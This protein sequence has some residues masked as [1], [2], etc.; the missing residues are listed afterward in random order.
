MVTGDIFWRFISNEYWTCTKFFQ[1]TS[2][3]FSTKFNQQCRWHSDSVTKR[4]QRCH[5]TIS[6]EIVE[7]ESTSIGS[8]NLCL[9]AEAANTRIY[10]LFGNGNSLHV[11]SLALYTCHRSQS[12][13]IRLTL[14]VWQCLFPLQVWDWF[15]LAFSSNCCDSNFSFSMLWG[16]TNHFKHLINLERLP[17]TITYLITLL[18]TIYYSVWVKKSIE[19]DFTDRLRRSDVTRER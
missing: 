12:S 2:R 4:R 10:D 17:F 9:D 1:S 19:H 6:S 15:I 8:S 7:E 16:P 5:L 18:A 3:E 11:F 14:L 13:K